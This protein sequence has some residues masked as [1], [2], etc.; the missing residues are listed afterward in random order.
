MG[1]LERV[2][3][4]GGDAPAEGLYEAWLRSQNTAPGEVKH[5]NP[6]EDAY[7]A[8]VRKRMVEEESRRQETKGGKTAP[9]GSEEPMKPD[10]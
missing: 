1:T 3:E 8:W 4:D 5:R 6:P 7:D 2:E 9:R 10:G